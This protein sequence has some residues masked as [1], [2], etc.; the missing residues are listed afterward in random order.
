MV[1]QSYYSVIA[2]PVY[3]DGE[4]TGAVAVILDVTEKEKM[5]MM[6]REFTSN[7]SHELKTPLTS[8][9]GAAE[10]IKSGMVRQ[11]DLPSFGGM[12]FDESSRLV[13]LID[14]ILRLSQFDEEKIMLE[15]CDCDLYDIAEE[16]IKRLEDTA[17]ERNVAVTLK[18]EH[19]TVFGVPTMLDEMI[20]NLCENAV[21]YNN[22][23]GSVLITVMGQSDGVRFSVADTG[24]GIAQEQ[25]SRVFERFYRADK[26][27]SKSIGGTG[28]GLSIVKHAAAF[29]NAVVDISS[30]ENVGTTVTVLFKNEEKEQE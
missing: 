29:H 5:D 4:I 14:D 12:I 16:V 18:G 23:N 2:N 8:I 17:A 6:R 13:T 20:Y 15:K 10:L 9:K 26:S 25:L 28:L 27:R 1:G 7:V 22:E 21:K 24:I 3:R 11:E 30:T 19:K